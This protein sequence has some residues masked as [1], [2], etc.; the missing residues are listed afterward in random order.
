MSYRRI[1]RIHRGNISLITHENPHEIVEIIL[2][3]RTKWIVVNVKPSVSLKSIWLSY[4]L[5]LSS[6]LDF[7]SFFQTKVLRSIAD[8]RKISKFFFF[9]FFL[10]QVYFHKRLIGL[11]QESF[12]ELLAGR[13]QGQCN[14]PNANEQNHLFDYNC[15]ITIISRLY[16]TA[17]YWKYAH[18]LKITLFFERSSLCIIQFKVWSKMLIHLN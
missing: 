13:G 9:C 16:P 11:I 2:K 6:Q 10:E 14:E 15:S 3:G 4:S 17:H 12:R 8:K 7:F 18:V 5:L 1:L